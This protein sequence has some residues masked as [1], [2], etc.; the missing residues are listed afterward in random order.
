METPSRGELNRHGKTHGSG[1]IRS[2]TRNHRSGSLPT[3]DSVIW[4]SARELGGR[5]FDFPL[6]DDAADG[7]DAIVAELE[8]IQPSPPS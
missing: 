2:V 3:N 1:R 8:S 7:D 6:Q 4:S 5:T